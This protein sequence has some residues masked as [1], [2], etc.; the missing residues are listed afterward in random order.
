MKQSFNRTKG[1]NPKTPGFKTES[2]DKN[3][4]II[5]FC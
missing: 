4:R 3:N 1:R 2:N 5:P